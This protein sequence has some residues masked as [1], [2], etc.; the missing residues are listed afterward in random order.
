[1][2]KFEKDKVIIEIETNGSP[3]ET[4]VGIYWGVVDILQKLGDDDVIPFDVYHLMKSMLPDAK[5]CKY[6]EDKLLK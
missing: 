5:Y 2:V 3:V 1:M 4:W 6:I